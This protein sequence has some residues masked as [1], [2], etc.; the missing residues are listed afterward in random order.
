MMR[1]NEWKKFKMMGFIAVGIGILG[2]IYAGGFVQAQI[3]L[4][5]NERVHVD[6]QADYEEILAC[7]NEKEWGMNQAPPEGILIDDSEEEIDEPLE[8][9]LEE[10]TEDLITELEERDEDLEDDLVINLEGQEWEWTAKDLD[11]ILACLDGMGQLIENDSNVLIE[12][13]EEMNDDSEEELNDNSEEEM[14]DDSEKELNDNSEE[15]MSNDLEEEVYLEIGFMGMIPFEDLNWDAFRVG[16][17]SDL[18]FVDIIEHNWE[19]LFHFQPSEPE[20]SGIL[21]WLY[22][23]QDA[24][25]SEGP[26]YFEFPEEITDEAF[27]RLI[28]EEGIIW[29]PRQVRIGTQVDACSYDKEYTPWTEGIGH[30][31]ETI[32]YMDDDLFERLYD[33]AWTLR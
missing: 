25:T 30:Y 5:R 7:L 12:P 29:L 23:H 21:N 22:E 15:E 31:C 10:I 19:S 20:I 14:N 33:F 24:F 32:F 11:A 8:D 27:N 13:E 28:D 18:V 1:M 9:D 4:G 17:A 3:G 2:L 16:D 26:V 6:F